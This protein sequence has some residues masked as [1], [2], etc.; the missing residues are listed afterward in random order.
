MVL[1]QTDQVG[2][3]FG[4]NA[5]TFYESVNHASGYKPG[6]NAGLYYKSDLRHKFFFRSELFYSGQG[7]Y[8]V[9][10]N[11]TTVTSLNYLNLPLLLE[12]GNR[13][14]FVIGPQIGFLL[15]AHKNGNLTAGDNLRSSM[16][17]ADIGIVVGAN[18]QLNKTLHAGV[19]LNQGIS[20]TFLTRSKTQNV[21]V[22]FY[23][24][25]CLRSELVT[26]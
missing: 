9:D 8:S 11:L 21:V 24:G 7:Q 12:Y 13:I 20:E 19:R 1:A 17:D 14:S 6:F 16:Y 3:K 23:F 25:V 5:S 18:L 15:S 4:M 2:I 22:N 10:G 26:K